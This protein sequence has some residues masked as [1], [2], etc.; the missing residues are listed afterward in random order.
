MSRLGVARLV[1]LAVVLAV[2]AVGV[3]VALGANG[4]KGKQSSAVRWSAERSRTAR[5]AAAGPFRYFF[6]NGSVTGGHF[7][8]G[9]V[10]CPGSNPH[11]IGGFFD[12]N[13]VAVFLA[14]NKPG[15]SSNQWVVGVTN[16]GR[17]R[18]GVTIGVVCSR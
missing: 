5:A 14:T 13:S 17:S 18:A 10:S 1:G 2:A 15:R 12:S 3:S 8:Q 7:V 4:H 6:R 16:T 11:A 9:T